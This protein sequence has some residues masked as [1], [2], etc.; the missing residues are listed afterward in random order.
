MLVYIFATTPVPHG[1]VKNAVFNIP[2]SAG[3]DEARQNVRGFSRNRGLF[4]GG[5]KYEF[6]VLWDNHDDTVLL[7]S[8]ER[9]FPVLDAAAVVAGQT[10]PRGQRGGERPAGPV[11]QGGFQEL[12]D[13]DLPGAADDGY[14]SGGDATEAAYMDMVQDGGGF[15]ETARPPS[16]F[17]PAMTQQ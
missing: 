9:M 6:R 17:P 7:L 10:N 16:G 13:V 12:A 11:A 2:G 15:R 1:G 3:T 4:T 5:V 8:T 14:L